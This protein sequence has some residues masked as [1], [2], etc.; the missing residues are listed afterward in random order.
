MGSPIEAIVVSNTIPQHEKI[1][2]C[3]KIQV[4]GSHVTLRSHSAVTHCGHT[5]RS[6]IAIAHLSNHY[7]DVNYD[8][9]HE[10]TDYYYGYIRSYS[11]RIYTQ[12]GLLGECTNYKHE[13]ME[14]SLN[15]K[16]KI[17]SQK[18]ARDKLLT[19]LNYIL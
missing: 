1:A 13:E 10:L 3:P 7:L 16:I 12:R 17:L 18:Q 8:I 9:V 4:G 11:I 5:L 14:M 6:H 19:N 15:L 2:V